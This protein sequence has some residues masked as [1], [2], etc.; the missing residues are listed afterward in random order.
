MPLDLSLAATSALMSPGDLPPSVAIEEKLLL[1]LPD[2]LG[3]HAPIWQR[4]AEGAFEDP[5]VPASDVEGLAAEIRMLR[6]HWLASQ[7]DA[8]IAARN[9]TARDDETRE[10]LA[11]AA[12]LHRDDPTRDT[13]DQLLAL[14]AAA[15]AAETGLDGVSD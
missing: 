13:L 14:C 7:R 6:E 12:L 1:E 4:L 10:A 5:E 15:L 3:V 8:V 9:I 2:K 11:D